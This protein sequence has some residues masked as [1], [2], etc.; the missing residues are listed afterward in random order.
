[1]FHCLK[2]KLSK[3]LVQ[4]DFPDE[5]HDVERIR[6]NKRINKL[7]ED[8]IS[9]NQSL[10]EKERSIQLLHKYNQNNTFRIEQVESKNRILSNAIRLIFIYCITKI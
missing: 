4:V 10:D 9:I 8:L 7:N 1:M 5:A 3:N 2:N 6:M